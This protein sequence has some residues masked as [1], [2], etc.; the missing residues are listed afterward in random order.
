MTRPLKAYS[1]LEHDEYTGGIVFARTAAQARRDGANAFH[2]GDPDYVFSRREPW[3][4]A[5]VET[6]QVPAALAVAHGWNF[7]CWCGARIS[8][9]EHVDRGLPIE[10]ILGTVNGSAYCSQ[11]CVDHERE[12]KRQSAIHKGAMLGILREMLIRRMPDARILEDRL[13][14]YAQEDDGIW[15]VDEASVHFEFPGMK[16]GPASLDL[17]RGYRV[18]GPLRPTFHCCGGDREAFESWALEQKAK[19]AQP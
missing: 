5:Y 7:E 18:I 14:A 11:A 19:R 10:G 9:D 4:D 3:A 15:I 16:H 8:E 12:H 1:V 2:G 13:H 6:G 17:R